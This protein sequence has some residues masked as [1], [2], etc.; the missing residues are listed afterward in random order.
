MFIKNGGQA[1]EYPQTACYG[2]ARRPI[3]R[4]SPEDLGRRYQVVTEAAT[5]ENGKLHIVSCLMCVSALHK[6]VLLLQG[7][8]T[9][10]LAVAE[11]ASNV[12]EAVPT[13][14]PDVLDASFK[15][16]RRQKASD[17]DPHM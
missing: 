13:G 5:E 10:S 1:K 6:C 2:R 7:I 17:E 9:G 11:K 12:G 4:R 3:R 14:G 16:E 15:Q 8:E